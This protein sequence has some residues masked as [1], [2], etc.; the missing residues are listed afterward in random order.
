[1][2][3]K[4]RQQNFGWF[5]LAG[6]LL[7]FTVLAVEQVRVV[8][9]FK[10]KGM[11]GGDGR[12]HFLRAGESTVEGVKLVSA[13]P[14]EAILELDGQRESYRLGGHVGGRFEK[15]KLAEVRISRAPNGAYLTV[16]SING[17]VTNM[18][19]DTGATSVAMSEVEAKRLGISYRL[20]G[21]KSGVSTAS[22]FAK[23]YIVT[24]DRVRVGEIILRQVK[25]F[26]VEGSSPKQV[27]L[28]MSF[29]NQVEMKNEGNL[30]ILKNKF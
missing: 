16:G 26:V 18:L 2:F 10:N 4:R 6:L 14:D 1:M 22:G 7:S 17:R 15:R 11:G 21:K 29:L 3:S 13:T 23:A 5:V 25:A 20:K 12:R 24:L 8:A 28:G 9:L 19:V 30:M 27:L